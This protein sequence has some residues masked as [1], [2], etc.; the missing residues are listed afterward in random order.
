MSTPDH[1]VL[2]T[3]AAGLVGS[4]LRDSLADFRLRLQ[5]RKLGSV[6]PRDH[7]ETVECDLDDFE[8]MRQAMQGC[9]SVVHLAADPRV[10]ASWEDLRSPNFDGVYHVFE[11]AR[12]AGTRRVVFASSNHVTGLLDEQQEWPIDPYGAV[13]P[14]SLYGVSKAFGE[15]VGRYYS[16]RFDLSVVCLRIGWVTREPKPENPDWR[17]MWLSFGDLGQLVHKSLTADVQFGIY[18]GVSA[19]TPM[20]YELANARTELGYEPVDDAAQIT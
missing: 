14:D 2:L 15:A 16:D 20:R 8:G 19:N 10:P 5:D 17:R 9:D 11:A 3:G 12:L 1:C 13:A 7:E 4:S 6:Q 18:Y